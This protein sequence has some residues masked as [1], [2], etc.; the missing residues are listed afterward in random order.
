M[1]PPPNQE[2]AP[3]TDTYRCNKSPPTPVLDSTR[4]PTP[5]FVGLRPYVTISQAPLE[6]PTPAT[7][8]STA[9]PPQTAARSPRVVGQQSTV[10]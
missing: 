5:V 9:T 6:S 8:S 3:I 1:P 10:P 2:V 7:A 4:R